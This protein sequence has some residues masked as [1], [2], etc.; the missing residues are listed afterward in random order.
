MDLGLRGLIKSEEEFVDTS[1]CLFGCL[2]MED[3]HCLL[4][5]DGEAAAYEAPVFFCLS[6]TALFADRE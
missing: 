5:G 2:S 3:V 1:V 6:H 4:F